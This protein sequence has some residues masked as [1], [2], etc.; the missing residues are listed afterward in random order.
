MLIYI[1]Q[2]IVLVVAITVIVL[3][4]RGILA[5]ERL[6]AFVA[7]AMDE[8]WGMYIAVGVRLLLG[9]ALIIAA[10]VTRYP[11]V[12]QVLGVIALVAAVILVLMGRERV[13]K[14]IVWWIEKMSPSLIR[15]WLLFGI[16]FG[17]FLVFGVL[18]IRT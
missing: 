12:F 6:V 9:A 11:V 13:R 5:P 1:S 17:G 2:I 10:P 4:A 7:S 3:A 8:S 18:N 16:A 15:M 14:F